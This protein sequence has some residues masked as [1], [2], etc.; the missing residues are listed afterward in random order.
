MS[1]EGA[2]LE[3]AR[4]LVEAVQG[5]DAQA[6][7]RLRLIGFMPR[8]D[9]TYQ[10]PACWVRRGQR[11]DISAI[12]GNQHFDALRCNSCGAEYLIEI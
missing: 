1:I 11:G 10:C 6:E 5:V 3:E 7:A 4:W 8:I 9:H 2:L 12:P